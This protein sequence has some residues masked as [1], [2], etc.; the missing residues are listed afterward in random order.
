MFL[1]SA[2]L[3][4]GMQ[5]SP[6]VRIGIP[7]GGPCRVTVNGSVLTL[8]QLNRLGQIWR[9]TQPEI[10]FKPDPD[11]TYECV[12]HVLRIIKQNGLTKLGF[13]GNEL[14]VAEGPR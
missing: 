12:D 5:T 7:K 1:L 8:R 3:L 2:A 9:R 6:V 14:Y 4:L 11:A 10:H 13:V